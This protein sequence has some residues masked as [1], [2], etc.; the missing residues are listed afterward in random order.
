MFQ[1][2]KLIIHICNTSADS[3]ENRDISFNSTVFQQQSSEFLVV[4]G[5]QGQS[6]GKPTLLPSWESAK[7]IS[8]HMSECSKWYC[9]IPPS[10]CLHKL[11]SLSHIFKLPPCCVV[12]EAMWQVI[13]FVVMPVNFLVTGSWKVAVAKTQ[14]PYLKTSA[15]VDP[16]LRKCKS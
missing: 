3:E 1:I 15:Q 14:Q 10:H 9:A 12:T 8:N 4:M 11:Q 5:Y 6:R 2:F 16:L 7:E 13:T